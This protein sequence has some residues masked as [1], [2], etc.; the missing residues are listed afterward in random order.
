MRDD[1]RAYLPVSFGYY[2]FETDNFGMFNLRQEMMKRVCSS[3]FESIH[4][5]GMNKDRV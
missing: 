2:Y 5:G 1:D 4:D 3:P